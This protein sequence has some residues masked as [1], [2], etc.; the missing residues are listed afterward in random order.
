LRSITLLPLAIVF[1]FMLTLQTCGGCDQ[2]AE[3][4]NPDLLDLACDYVD[5]V[6]IEL[7]GVDSMTVFDLLKAEHQVEYRSSMAGTFVTA[8]NSVE[9][10]SDYFWIYSVNDSTPSIACDKL[11]TSDGDRVKWHFRRLK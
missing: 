4:D 8:I 7:A 9:S 6:V 5:S 10:G 11:V 3:R 2:T 1:A